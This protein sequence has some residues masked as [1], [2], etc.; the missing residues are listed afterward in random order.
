MAKTLYGCNVTICDFSSKGVKNRLETFTYNASKRILRC[1][2]TTPKLIS[3]RLSDIEPM[4]VAA[5][6]RATNSGPG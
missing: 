5:K 6:R 4:Y 2:K 3:I 1:S